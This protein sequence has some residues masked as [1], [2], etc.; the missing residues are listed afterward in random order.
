VAYF[1][2]HPADFIAFLAVH[3]SV[4]VCPLLL[5]AVRVK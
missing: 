3:I 1:L 2:G 4:A 5:H